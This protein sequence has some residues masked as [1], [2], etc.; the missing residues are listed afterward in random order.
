MNGQLIAIDQGMDAITDQDQVRA[1]MMA[2]TRIKGVTVLTIKGEEAK[3]EASEILFDIQE[4]AEKGEALSKEFRDPYF[5][6]SKRIKSFFDETLVPVYTKEKEVGGRIKDYNIKL[7]QEEAERLKKAQEKLNKQRE[8]NPDI[9]EQL[10]E[11]ATVTPI[12]TKTKTEKGTT[13]TKKVLRV[14]V[15]SVKELAAAVGVG[16][17]P[18]GVFDI[19]EGYIK[20][21]I[22]GGMVLPGVK[23]WE[24]DEIGTRR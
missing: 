12:S 16:A 19:K 3:K 13:F 5:Q 1:L 23:S 20:T 11:R 15:E 7:K 8:K 14:Q 22:K 21:L 9:A 17:V 10:P 2:V 18:E 6:M 4:V 24:E